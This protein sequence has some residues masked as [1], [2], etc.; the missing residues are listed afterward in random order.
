VALDIAMPGNHNIQNAM[1]AFAVGVAEGLSAELI[2]GA[3]SGL[4]AVPGRFE[5]VDEGQDFAVIVDYAHTDNALENVLKTAREITPN[6]LICLFGCG[7]D[8]D[9]GKRALMGKVASEMADIVV[10]TSDNPRTEDP[11]EII[12]AI[13]AGIPRERRAKVCVLLLR[14]E[15]IQHAVDIAVAGD[16]VLIAGKGHEDY[17]II[18]KTRHHFDDREIAAAA[19][20][21]MKR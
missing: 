8:R 7:G 9:T 12:N 4:R 17:Q 20:K 18:G 2:V 15:A 16:T 5:K 11:R 13:L 19:L 1:A 10:V 3:L 14:Q 21:G 6:R